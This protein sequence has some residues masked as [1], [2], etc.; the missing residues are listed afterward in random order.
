MPRGSGRP[1]AYCAHARPCP[2]IG[3]GGICR[4]RAGGLGSRAR[5]PKP[6]ESGHDRNGSLPGRAEW[7]AAMRDPGP[8]ADMTRPLPARGQAASSRPERLWLGPFAYRDHRGKSAGAGLAG[9]RGRR[10]LASRA[11]AGFWPCREVGSARHQ[12]VAEP[13]SSASG[14][15]GRA[16]EPEFQRSRP[17]ATLRM[18]AAVRHGRPFQGGGPMPF[19]VVRTTAS[20]CAGR[21]P[22]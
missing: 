15:A 1:V 14:A 22:Y 17:R 9:A 8:G 20:G 2:G 19:T 11:T 10:S 21:D 13:R 6:G 4:G 12:P 16:R 7:R 18:S 3:I 5:I